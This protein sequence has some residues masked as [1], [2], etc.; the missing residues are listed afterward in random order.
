[1]PPPFP[2]LIILTV[3]FRDTPITPLFDC[4]RHGRYPHF[5][6]MCDQG[7]E[8]AIVRP[9]NGLTVCPLALE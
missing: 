3:A 1:V 6:G 5:N 7:S 4:L 8:G 9:V 2:G